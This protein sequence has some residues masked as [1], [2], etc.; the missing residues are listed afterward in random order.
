MTKMTKMLFIRSIGSPSQPINPN[1]HNNPIPRGS[2]VINTSS[3]DA[4]VRNNS[5][6]TNTPV[7]NAN[8]FNPSRANP[9]M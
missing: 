5:A 4:S 9:A 6:A 7:H 3:T 1:V 8:R 2:N